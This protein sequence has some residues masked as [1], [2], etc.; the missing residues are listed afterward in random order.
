MTKPNKSTPAY[1]ALKSELET[2]MLELQRDDLA[3]DAA[4]QHYQRGLEL[5]QQ[6][7]RYLATAENT[8]RELKAKFNTGA[9]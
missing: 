8:V 6:L 3:I 5:V 4:L 7:E 1:A 9:Q 2:V